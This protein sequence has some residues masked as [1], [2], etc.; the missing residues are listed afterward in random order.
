M[1]SKKL[2][3][4][5]L[6]KMFAKSAAYMYAAVA[7]IETST[8]LVHEENKLSVLMGVRLEDAHRVLENMK[9]T[10]RYWKQAK[11][12]MLARL[13]NLGPFQLFFTLSCAD[14]RWDENFAAILLERGLEMKYKIDED[15]EGNW[16]TVVEGRVKGGKWKPL[17]QCIEEDVDEGEC[18]YSNKILPA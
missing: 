11:Y 13:D 1:L 14:M 10:P 6:V 5:D 18:S 17:K 9:N 15:E 3:G 4:L 7:Y 16:K 2:S 8:W 12:E